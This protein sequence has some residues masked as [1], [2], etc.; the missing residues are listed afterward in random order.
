CTADRVGGTLNIGPWVETGSLDPVSI[1]GGTSGGQETAALFDTL[2]RFDP[3][4]G[5]N[6]P[7]VAESLTPD[8][9]NV[10]WTLK[11]RPDVKFGNGDPLTADA[12]K[13]S[14]ER[15]KDPANRSRFS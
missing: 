4:T 8:A 7:W 13:A 15:H 6:E 3:N 2:M 11:L 5:D 12:V 1:V 14:I 10:V 9:Q